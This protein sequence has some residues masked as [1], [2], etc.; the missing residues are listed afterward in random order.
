MKLPEFG[1]DPYSLITRDKLNRLKKSTTL[2]GS[3]RGEDTGN[4]LPLRWEKQTGEHG[5][6]R[7]PR[8]EMQE[9]KP[10]WKVELGKEI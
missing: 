7:F 3:V 2:L 1:S 10:P 5:E 6:L 9:Y 4:P 8:V